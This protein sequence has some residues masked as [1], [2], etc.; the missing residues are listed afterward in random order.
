MK[1]SAYI[2]QSG[3]CSRRKAIDLIKT[4]SITVNHWKVT[5]PGYL[6]QDK[7]TIRFKKDVITISHVE[8]IYIAVN[9]PLGIVTT[10][11]DTHG[12]PTVIDLLGK[13]W[14]Q[15]VFPIGRLDTHTSGIIILTNDGDMCHKLAHP[16]YNI[17]KV[18]QITLSKPLEAEHARLITKGLYLKDGPIKV[19]KLEQGYNTTKVK[20][21]LHSGRNR[22]V[23]RI[24]ESLG[25]KTKSLERINFAGISK[26]GLAQG[27]W[28]NLT[29]KEVERLKHYITGLT[30]S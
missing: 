23:R 24:F 4:G 19:D 13:K 27:E 21:T 30:A 7:D 1:L 29:N 9:K 20:I 25:Y 6:V 18:Y 22:I 14:K 8:P 11:S 2:T 16:R 3:L 26:K 5:D 17:K 12:R 15:R 28:R 10:V